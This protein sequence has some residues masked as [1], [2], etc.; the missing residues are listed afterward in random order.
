MLDPCVLRLRLCVRAI[1]ITLVQ[2]FG[3]RAPHGSII[4]GGSATG[5]V[6][7]AVAARLVAAKLPSVDTF[8]EIDTLA[9][10]EQVLM[11]EEVGHGHACFVAMRPGVGGDALKIALKL[12]RDFGP[13]GVT[14]C[15]PKDK[16][17]ALPYLRDA[18][19][20][21]RLQARIGRGSDPVK[22][23]SHF[24]ISV[25]EAA[26]G[27]SRVVAGVSMMSAGGGPH[28][29]DIRHLQV[30]RDV[31]E[32]VLAEAWLQQG[33]AKP[34]I[35]VATAVVLQHLGLVE[36]PADT[37][38]GRNTRLGQFLTILVWAIAQ[39]VRGDLRVR[40]PDRPHPWHRAVARAVAKAVEFLYFC[41][42]HTWTA[43][44]D[45]D[46]AYMSVLASLPRQLLRTCGE[47]FDA[48]LFHGILDGIALHQPARGEHADMNPPTT[49]CTSFG[50]CVC[51]YPQ[52]V[53]PRAKPL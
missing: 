38:A 31:G 48:A 25:S 16:P 53:R 23:D 30:A 43:D 40:C 26:V 3:R 36:A 45:A 4:L 2:R 21:V 9:A 14:T 6:H 52:P 27:Y 41:R 24:L 15:A 51:H 46:A 33:H 22:R 10:Q 50:C 18:N 49:V 47:D 7:A 17:V 42:R 28:F 1:S 19:K 5:A 37:S 29:T 12:V 39:C 44:E 20:Y 32:L 8:R 34:R 35:H 11:Q 13:H